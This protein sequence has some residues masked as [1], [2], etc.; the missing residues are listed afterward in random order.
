MIKPDDAEGR[1]SDVVIRLAR[2]YKEE[3]D[4]IKMNET[5]HNGSQIE[6]KKVDD[7]YFLWTEWTEMLMEEKYYSDALKIIKHILL[8]KRYRKEDEDDKARQA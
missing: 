5:M 2:I 8:K 1:L 6:Y 4:L 3:G 7:Y